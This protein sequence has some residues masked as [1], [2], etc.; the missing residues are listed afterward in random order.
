[1]SQTHN[2]ETGSYVSSTEDDDDLQAQNAAGLE[3]DWDE[4]QGEAGDAD[5]DVTKSLFGEERLPNPEAA[6]SY[7]AAKHGFD[8]RQF[9][10]QVIYTPLYKSAILEGLC[11][12]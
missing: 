3:E 4:W 5:E 7:D 10:I 1:M 12:Y 2:E 9:A 8:I 11:N 6:M